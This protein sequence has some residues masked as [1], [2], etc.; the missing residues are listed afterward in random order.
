[1]RSAYAPIIFM[2]MDTRLHQY[3]GPIQSRITI[4]KAKNLILIFLSVFVVASIGF[5]FYS[6]TRESKT[7]S[8]STANHPKKGELVAGN[9][10]LS[11]NEK[12]TT[13]K[14]IRVYYFHTTY[15]CLTCRRI[16]EYTKKAIESSFGPELKKGSII[17]KT[18]NVEEPQNR[19]YAD[20]FK[21]FTKSVVVVDEQEGKQIRWKIL[22]K[23]W[24]LVHN[25]TEFTDYIRSELN[26]YLEGA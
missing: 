26:K 16:E 25:Q 8:T 11:S 18:I 4:M 21:L 13:D 2:H 17:W 3:K 15:R 19:H 6:E 22:E 5:L 7:S 1:M 14:I 23:T 10:A 24:E 20:D 12:Q 9:A